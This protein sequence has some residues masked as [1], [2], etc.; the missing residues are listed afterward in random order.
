MSDGRQADLFAG[1]GFLAAPNA[2]CR[3][4]PPPVDWA[5]ATDDQLVTALAEAGLTDAP[6]MAVEVGRRRLAIA[7][8][9]LE[10]LCGRFRGFGTCTIVR[11]QAAALDALAQIGGNDAAAAVARLIARAA[12]Q[13]P[14]LRHAVR[15]A[16]DLGSALSAVDVLRLLHDGD[17]AVR[18]EACRC[19]GRRPSPEAAA[20]LIDLLEDLHAA[21][22]RAAACALG[23]AGR[24]EGRAVLLACLRDEPSA[25]VVEALAP[26]AD[27]DCI[28]LLGRLAATSDGLRK[29]VLATLDDID[30]PRAAAIAARLRQLTP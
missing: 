23:R 18:S 17:P 10:R 15:A 8:P 2:P 3:P 13:G 16:A 4:E 11:E 6:V 24:R 1:A 25:E 21:V 30:E 14:G 12:V 7:V 19:L 20:T 29:A 26:V 28:V 9:A 5:T 22:R 27:A